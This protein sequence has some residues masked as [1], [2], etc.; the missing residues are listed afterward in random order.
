MTHAHA[1]FLPWWKHDPVVQEH[2]W[3][4]ETKCSRC[5]QKLPGDNIDTDYRDGH[6]VPSAMEMLDVVR[7]FV[8]DGMSGEDAVRYGETW[9]AHWDPNE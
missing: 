9:L 6:E 8:R 1:G 2:G 7:Q 5:G 3:W 4:D